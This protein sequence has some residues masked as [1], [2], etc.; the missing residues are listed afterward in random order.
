MGEYTAVWR[1]RLLTTTDYNWAGYF[2]YEPT[3]QDIRDVLGKIPH[4]PAP[5][6]ELAK[7]I[8]DD[9]INQMNLI[10]VLSITYLT[11]EGTISISK[12][13]AHVA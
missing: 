4:C 3:P 10:G 2:M 11:G 9:Y 8:P 6:L 1:V 13:K 12:K 5:L 7:H